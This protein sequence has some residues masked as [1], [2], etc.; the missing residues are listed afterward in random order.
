MLPCDEIKPVLTVIRVA[1]DEMQASLVPLGQQ[2]V[3]QKV[4]T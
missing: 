3:G 1:E 4:A 2:R